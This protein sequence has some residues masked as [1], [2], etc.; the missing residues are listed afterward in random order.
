MRRGGDGDV[1]LAGQHAR[2]DVEAD[3]ARAGQIDF[4]P[5]VQVGEVALDLARAFERIDVGTKLDQ[6]AGD[7]ARGEA[8]MA[9]R[10]DQQPRGV[11][12]GAGA[13][14]QRL[15][16]RLDAGLHADDVADALLQ[17]G[18]EIDQEVDGAV[19]LGAES[20]SR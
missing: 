1:P 9:Q 19:G 2:G 5:G 16:R 20:A 10:L 8:E 3:P 11:A 4:G 13:L 12:A 17:G 14:R 6:I 15:F 18:V 7:E